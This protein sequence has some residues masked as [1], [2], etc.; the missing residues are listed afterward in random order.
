MVKDRLKIFA[1]IGYPV[2]HTLSPYMHNAAFSKLKIK[3]LYIPLSV[4]PK[5]LRQTI[6]I[7]KDA[8]IGGFNV[9][10]PFKSICMRYLDRVDKLASMIGAVNT[11]VVKGKRLIGY[12]T[13]ATGFLKSLK[14]DLKFTPKNKSVLL[15]GAGGAARAVAF[16]LAKEGAKKIFITDIVKTKAVSLAKNI[17]KYFPKCKIKSTTNYDIDLL[18][19][20]TPLG[21]KKSDPLLV[22]PKLLHNRLSIYDIVYNPSP[23]KFVKTAKKRKI[24]AVNGLGMLLYQGAEA[25]K[26]WTGRRAPVAVMRKTLLEHIPC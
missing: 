11:V 10:I 6:K 2:G 4:E 24:K 20:A 17:R 19:N 25:F 3:A 13:D 15:I 26:L 18:V 21:M 8:N 16:A 23:T 7:L 22:N 5:R 14:E 12:N 9:T 1:L